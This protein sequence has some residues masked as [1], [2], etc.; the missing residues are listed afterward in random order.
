MRK[1]YALLAG[2]LVCLASI[3]AKTVTPDVAN[4]TFTIDAPNNNVFFTNTSTIGSEPGPRKAFWNFG[5][6]IIQMTGAL[7]NTQHH[8]Q[9]AGTY[10]V[11]LKIYRYRPNHG[12]SVLT[13]QICKTLVIQVVCNAEFL[14]I[15]VTSNPLLKYFIAQPSHNQNKKPVQICWQFG[16]GRDTCITYPTTYTGAYG[17]SHLYAH[18]G[19]YNVCVNINYYGGCQAQKCH[20]VQIGIPDSCRAD[21]ERIQS[22]GANPLQAYYKALPQHNNNR[23]PSRICWVFGDGRDTCINYPANYTGQYVVSHLYPNP[24][25]YQVCV[26]IRYYGGCEASKCKPIQ[27]GRPD[28]CRADFERLPINVTNPRLAYYKAL[29]QHN[30]N[31][32]PS[33]ICWVF[34]D[35]RDTCINYPAN[36]TGQYVV[37]HLYPHPGQYQVCVNIR[38]YGG[39]EASKCKPIQIGRP[40]S[41]RADFERIPSPNANPLRAYFK[42]LPSH[43]NNKKPQRICWRFGDGRDTCI[44]YPNN[45]TGQYVVSHT[46]QHRGLYEVCV[47][48]DYFGGCEARKCKEIRIGERPD[49]CRADFVKLPATVNN[50]LRAYFKALPSHNNNKKPQRICWRFGDGQDTCINYPN[51][52]TGQYIVSHTY[53]QRGL[54]EVCVK[55]DYFGGCEARKC[56]NVQ[57]G[58]RDSCSADFEREPVHGTSPLTV[59][60]KALPWNNNNRK[61]SRICWQFGDGRDTC[62]N[63]P[64]NYSGMYNVVHHYQQPGQYEVCVRIIYYGGC[65]ARKCKNIVVPPPQAVCS[66]RLFEITPSIT[67]LTR[68]FVAIPS[69]TPPRRPVS[70]CWRFGDGQDTCIMV[71]STQPNLNFTIRHTYPGPGVYHACVKITY[72]GGCMATDCKEVVIRSAASICGGFMID[73]LM[74]PRTFK[75]KGFS[76]HAP[77]DEVIGYRWT[78]GDGTSATGREVTKTYNHGGNY[79]VCLMIKTRLGCETKICRTVRVPGNNQPALVLTPNPVISVMHVN[80]FSTHTEQVNVKILNAMGN[81]VRMFTRNV[82]VGP[83]NWSHD[84]SNLLPGVYSYIVQSPNQLASAIFIKL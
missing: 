14:T 8:Y 34:G 43:N 59:G 3:N 4:F 19:N 69:S 63:Y 21:F 22:T 2:F 15:A 10:N 62:I 44:N 23:K 33:R 37:S 24:G 50:P 31:R 35:G 9:V 46:Y 70:V 32:K 57:I 38:Y 60:L 66:V 76:I 58:Q 18:P 80:Y 77:N 81:Q 28:S 83:N 42:A 7:S 65:E 74:A 47:K 1:L 26:N 75:F 27:I 51:S 68:G 53:Q 29:P 78:F 71:D 79:E 40:D 61:P 13:A 25:Q 41:C 16:D 72:Q 49:T 12:D 52:Y 73:S 48:I 5:D 84:L 54:Y 56:D 82:N 6:G 20:P 67:S 45:Y 55:I 36:Y 17:V 11:C 39:C 64:E 30:N